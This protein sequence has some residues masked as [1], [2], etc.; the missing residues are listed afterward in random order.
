[1]LPTGT[2]TL[3][4]HLKKVV[5]MSDHLRFQSPPTMPPTRGYTHVVDTTAPYRAVYTSGQLGFTPEGQLASDFRGQA[6]QCFVNLKAALAATGADFSHV[7]KI[8][9]FFVNMDDLQTFFEVR[10][11][12]VNTEA[13]PA[14]TAIQVSRLAVPGA[15]YEIEAVALVPL[16]PAK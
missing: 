4:Y 1:M 7:V 10:D 14:S 5:R 16:D 9:N 13:P 2:I 11:R 3:R 15:L 8:T 12:Y 6:T